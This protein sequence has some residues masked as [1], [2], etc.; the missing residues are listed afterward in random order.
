MS[1]D[2]TEE[3]DKAVLNTVY[4]C[5]TCN[6]IIEPGDADISMHKR[7]LPHHKMRRVMILRCGRCGNIVTDSYAQYSLEKNQFWCKDCLFATSSRQ[8][9]YGEDRDK[10]TEPKSKK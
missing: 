2:W 5:E 10:P 8:D 6:L 4:Y 7:D 3:R 1:A 9:F